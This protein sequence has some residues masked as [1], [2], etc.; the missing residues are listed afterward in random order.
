LGFGIGFGEQNLPMEIVAFHEIAI[1]NSHKANTSADE[2]IST[3]A[4]ECSA[5]NHEH[6]CFAQV[7][8]P[9]FAKWGEACL[10][11]IAIEGIAHCE[12][13]LTAGCRLRLA[14]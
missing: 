6:T 4:T 9:L 5:T 11:A 2:Q 10:A 13:V 14:V 8:L 1:N 7:T 3:H 12:L